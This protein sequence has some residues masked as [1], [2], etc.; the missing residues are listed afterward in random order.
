MT[1]DEACDTLFPNEADFPPDKD[2][3]MRDFLQRIS[4]AFRRFMT[5][6]YGSDQLSRF[7]LLL[8]LVM[9]VLNM[10]FRT[11]T[12]VFYWLVWVCLIITYFRMFSKNISKRYDEN[13]RFLQLK[14]K[15]MEKLRGGRAGKA[16]DSVR[17]SY[18]YYQN[19]YDN[20]R[21]GGTSGN[22]MRSDKEHRIFRCPNCDQRVRVPRGRGKIEITCP[23]CSHKFIK[24]S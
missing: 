4:N 23:R 19:A 21:S 20:A 9:L 3:E 10:I 12:S 24:R 18:R 16:G 17:D 7:T 22:T 11:R 2:N 5:G 6:R 15:I 8:A 13:T 1:P 14:E